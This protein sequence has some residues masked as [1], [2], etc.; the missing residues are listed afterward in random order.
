MFK[1]LYNYHV[2]LDLFINNYLIM[3]KHIII[4]L[5][6]VFLFSNQLNAQ[7]GIGKTSLTNTSVLLE[8]GPEN[9]GIILPSVTSAPDASGGTFVYNSTEKA[10]EVWEGKNNSN[11]GGWTL[12]TDINQGVNHN[13]SNAGLDNSVSNG[14][15]LGAASTTKTGVLVLESTTKA[16]VLPK[17]SNPQT[18]IKGA[19]AGTMVYDT[20]SDMLAVYDGANWSFWK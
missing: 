5:I 19:I 2:P 4:Q 12:L 18:S 9:K 17:V 16:L 6:V 14:V 15:I 13:L 10:I 3:K 20:A 1:K 8:F 11:I 7:L